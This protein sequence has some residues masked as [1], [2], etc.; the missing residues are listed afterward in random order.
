M[1]IAT[2]THIYPPEELPRSILP[3]LTARIHGKICAGT[4]TE[5]G[6]LTAPS[7]SWAELLTLA[8]YVLVEADG[9]KGLPLKAHRAFEPGDSCRGPAGHRGAGA[10]GPE[11]SHRRSGPLSGPLRPGSA[12]LRRRIWP[13]RTG[14]R[15]CCGPRVA[16]TSWC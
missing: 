5:T 6:K 13:R 16:S 2:S 11:P 12:A 15:R 4:P 14:R 8:D 3:P 7:Q 10:L 9:S 1:I